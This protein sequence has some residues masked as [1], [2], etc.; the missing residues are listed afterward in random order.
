MV[1][2]GQKIKI[3][4]VAAKDGEIVKFSEVLLWNDGEKT[5]IGAP[6]LK[7][8]IKGKVL[9]TAK[10]EKKI[11]FK[12]KAKKRQKKKKGHRQLFTEVEVLTV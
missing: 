7:K 2:P 3:E 11:V 5:E 12:Y 4:K 10:G 6:F 8:E 1:S 9:K